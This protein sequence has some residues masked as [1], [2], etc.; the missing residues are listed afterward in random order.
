MRSVSVRRVERDRTT[1]SFVVTFREDDQ[2]R[3]RFDIYIGLTEGTVIKMMLEGETSPRPLTHDLFL[4]ALERLSV[5]VRHVVLTH[6]SNGTFH[7]EITFVPDHGEEVTVS[8]RPSDGTA[9]AL[10][11]NA[12]LYASEALLD[13]V[14]QTTD[15]GEEG[16]E[17]I[18]D[19]FKEFIENISPEDFDI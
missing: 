1:N 9:L 7:A 15:G 19:E 17:E 6:V 18:L 14:G 13:E 16:S 2:P 12:P 4:I 3:R 11:A 8:C 10:K 5:Q